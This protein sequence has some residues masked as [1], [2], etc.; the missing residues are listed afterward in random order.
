MDLTLDTPVQYVPRIGP[1]RAQLLEKLGIS[2]AGDLLFHPPHRYNDFSLVSDIGK[3]QPGE[4]VTVAGSVRFAKNLLTK[5]GRRMQMVSVSDPTGSLEAVFFN[6]PFLVRTFLPGT[7]VRMAGEVSWFGRKIA[8]MSPEYEINNTGQPLHTGRLVP[9][10]PETGGISSKWLRG[11]ISYLLS[12][13]GSSITDHLTP[14]V[15]SDWQLVSL[16]DAVRMMHF[17]ENQTEAAEAK[18]RLA[19]DELLTM[20]L[21]AILARRQWEQ[22][23][24]AHRVPVKDSQRQ[25]FLK[26]LPFK[27]TGDQHKALDDISA[28]FGKT[29]PMHRLLEGD[30]GS[31]KTIVATAAV[32]D[33]YKAGFQ[34]VLMAP[35]E[36]LAQQHYETVSRFLTPLGVRVALITGSYKSEMTL[37][38]GQGSLTGGF[39]PAYDVFVGTHALLSAS[40]TF[41]RIALIVIDEQQRFGVAQRRL[42]R[43]KASS[44][45]APH[46]LTMTA[47]PIPR[48]VALTLWG[49]LDISVI[50]QMPTGRMPVKTWVVPSDKRDKAYVW[51]RSR[52]SNDNAQAFIVC[53]L[54]EESETLTSVR[55]VKKEYDRLRREVFP[56]LRLALLHGK[57]KPAEKTRILAGLRERQSDILV[58]TPVVEVGI[59]IP[60]ATVMMIEAADRFGLG[61]LHQ[62]RGRVGRRDKESY[63][64]LFTESEDEGTIERL[65]AL[66]THHNGAELAEIDLTIRGPG[67]LFG[68]RQH[69]LPRLR[70]GSFMDSGLLHETRHA[71]LKLVAADP[72]LSGVPL[73]RE[74]LE[75]STIG[76]S[77]FD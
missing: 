64:L 52:L 32:Y 16:A 56:D 61:Q 37:N 62:L 66:E 70:Y 76:D 18:R 55:S 59:D 38:S 47:T 65:K 1:A 74:K 77:G 21:S 69:G 25:V 46:L 58:A 39:G 54:I 60:D 72:A 71:A 43:N 20:Q 17:P 75:R 33:V 27:L 73:L 22:S 10:Y 3:V 31:G 26:S 67:E 14:A 44:N 6:Q 57:M 24:T 4:T 19:Y 49:N 41:D 9:V 30:V 8:L 13:I 29:Y 2:T 68:T 51:I 36:I 45:V 42:L 40:V 53:P 5:S 28:D 35:T 12:E 50:S 48:T 15:L 23:V 34:S 7:P 63:C 11:R